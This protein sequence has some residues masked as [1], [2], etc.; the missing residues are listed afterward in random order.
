MHFGNAP[1]SFEATWTWWTVLALSALTVIIAL[2]RRPAA[3][4]ATCILA[5]VGLLLLACAA[6]KPTLLRPSTQSVTVMVDLSASTRTAT[7]RDRATLERRIR[8]LLRDTPYQVQFFADGT[9]PMDP[10]A[11]RLP[12]LPSDRTTYAPPAAAAVLLFSDCQFPLPEQSPPTYICV[13]TG[14]DDP[15]DAAV[16]N[17]EIRGRDAAIFVRNSGASRRLTFDGTAPA[18]PTTLPTGELVVSRPLA[19]RASQIAAELS[20]GDPWPENDSLRAIVPPSEQL[21]RWWVGKSS[22]GGAWRTIDPGRLPTDAAAYLDAGVIALDNIA[23]SDLTDLQQQRLQQYVRDLGGGLMIL[24]GDRAFAAGAYDG[25]P[26]DALSPLASNPPLPTTHWVLL[27]DGSGSMSE[28][29]PG[30]TRWKYVTDAIAGALPRLAPEDVASVGSFSDTLHWW[31]E[32]KPVR[33]AAATPLPPADAY[34]HGP[35]N[36]QPALESIARSTDG[37][38]PVQLLVL[39]DFDTQIIGA[40]ELAALLK[41]KNIHLH[42]LAIGEGTALPAL[43]QV[44]A[45]TGGSVLTQLDPARWASATRELAHA[46]GAKLLR[47]DPVR[48]AFNSAASHIAPQTAAPWNRVWLK[49][50]ATSLAEA[51]VGDETIPMAAEWNL[52]EGRVLAAAFSPRSEVVE[53]LARTVAKPPRDPRFHVSWQS[54]PMLRLVIDAIDGRQYLN[55][56]VLNLELLGLMRAVPQIAPGRYELAIESPG[57]PTIATLRAGGRVLERIALAGRYAP[58]FDAIG[59]DLAAMHELAR[60]SGGAVIPPD[61]S[62]AIDIRWPTR[63]VSV[64]S[65]MAILGAICIAMG[66]IAW[67]RW[68]AL[69]VAN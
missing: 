20:P 10:L 18:L 60:R 31:V 46:A 68:R 24:G 55:G 16:S 11:T 2:I 61:Q 69:Q 54:G 53:A 3:P 49:P 17:L 23:A 15:A 59:N 37:K 7:Y 22:P 42:L 25:T 52:G 30:G 32:G 41:S 13:D 8:E 35:T 65:E 28:A 6:G 39:S 14:L 57:S 45:A 64:A 21:E 36:L 9:R 12:D 26:L 51:R 44:A 63:H 56:Q 67:R 48:V 40:P 47:Q 58:E 1:L 50:S 33:E 66:L 27:A 38:M 34:P 4:G 5:T 29:V 19:D 62:K 43:R